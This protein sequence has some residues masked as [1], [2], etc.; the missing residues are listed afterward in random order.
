MINPVFFTVIGFLH[1][2]LFCVLYVVAKL[3]S[4]YADEA[5]CVNYL[6][7]ICGYLRCRYAEIN[8]QRIPDTSPLYFD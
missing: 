6:L 2:S 1:L 4:D 5:M 8:A 3:L 7:K